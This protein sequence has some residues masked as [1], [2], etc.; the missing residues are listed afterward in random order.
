VGGPGGGVVKTVETKSLF[1]KGIPTL[2]GEV[3]S[4]AT[5]GPLITP[6]RRLNKVG[7]PTNINIRGLRGDKRAA[8][9]EGLDL[10][11]VLILAIDTAKDLPKALI[12]D[13]FGR[14]LEKPFFFAVN[15]DGIFTLHQK[16]QHWVSCVKAL[17]VFVGIEVAGCYHDAIGESVAYN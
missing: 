1:P 9:L 8:E 12:C 10:S 3:L 17:R 6:Q 7:K 4:Y 14:V 16:I 5:R 2:F 13:Y 15:S 11:R